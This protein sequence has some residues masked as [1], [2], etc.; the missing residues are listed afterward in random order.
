[1]PPGR[2]QGIDWRGPPLRLRNAAR[3]LR[4]SGARKEV[5][6]QVWRERSG[7]RWI[8]GYWNDDRSPRRDRI[9]D[10]IRSTFEAPASV[11]DVGCNA[12]PNLRRIATEFPGCRLRGFDINA[13]AIT[14]ARQLFAQLGIQV[15]LAVGSLY[16]ILPSLATQSAD[17][18]VS[19]YVLAYVPPAN[20]RSV[21]ADIARIAIRGIVLAEP[22]ALGDQRTAGVLTVPWY[23]WRHDYAAVLAVLGVSSDRIVVSD[24]PEPGAPDSGLLVVDLR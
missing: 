8:A 14:T 11:L 18:V 16:D 7:D 2:K 5:S 22:H 24:L 23:D 17:V 4:M 9:I 12:G 15:D 1:M 19:S 6:E 13:G 20:L 3:R 21:L 10:A